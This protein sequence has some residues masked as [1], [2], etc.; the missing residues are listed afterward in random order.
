MHLSSI[1]GFLV[2]APVVWLSP[3]IWEVCSISVVWEEQSLE[4]GSFPNSVG[5]LGTLDREY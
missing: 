4:L 3:L 5:G 1:L 2:M